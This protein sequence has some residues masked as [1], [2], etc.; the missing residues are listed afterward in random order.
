MNRYKYI[1]KISRKLSKL[2]IEDRVALNRRLI[3]LNRKFEQK[4]ALFIATHLP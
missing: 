1:Q 4:K 3:N 2:N